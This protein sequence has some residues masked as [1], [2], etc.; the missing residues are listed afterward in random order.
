VDL[1]KAF[2][3]VP[4]EVIKWA[5]HKLRVEEWLLSAVL[6]MYTGA[7]IVVRTHYGNSNGFEVKV[8]LHQGSTLSPLQ[9]V[10]VI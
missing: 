5:M 7:K 1:E 2:D 9:F 10:I 8:G 3:G 4:R 6:S